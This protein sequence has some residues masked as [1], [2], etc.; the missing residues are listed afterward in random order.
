MIPGGR[1]YAFNAD[2]GAFIWNATGSTCSCGAGVVG[3]CCQAFAGGLVDHVP[4][5]VTLSDNSGTFIFAANEDGKLYKVNAANG[6]IVSSIDLKRP[7]CATDHLKAAPTIQMAQF[8]SANFNRIY[9]GHDIIFIPTAYDTGGACA[10]TTNNRIFAVDANTMTIA[11][12]TGAASLASFNNP[13]LQAL[14]EA[15]EGCELDD[16]NDIIYCAFR[17]PGGSQKSLVALQTHNS[18]GSPENKFKTVWAA[19]YTTGVNAGDIQV[20][21]FLRG[22]K[23]YVANNLGNLAAYNAANGTQ[24]WSLN[25]NCTTCNIQNNTWLESRNGYTSTALTVTADGRLHSVTDTTCAGLPCGVESWCRGCFDTGGFNTE[26]AVDPYLSK[27]YTGKTD[28]RLHQLNLTTGSDDGFIGV[29]PATSGIAMGDPSLDTF[30]GTTI[31][32]LTMGSA[33]GI[34][35]RICPPFP[36]GTMTATPPPPP[37]PLPTPTPND[38][39]LQTLPPVPTC[40]GQL[41][42]C[43]CDADCACYAESVFTAGQISTACMAACDQSSTCVSNRYGASPQCNT[44]RC[45][46]A[47][48]TCYATKAND[49]LGCQNGNACETNQRCIDGICRGIPNPTCSITNQC[50]VGPS[51][52]TFGIGKECNVSGVEGECCFNAFGQQACTPTSSSTSNCGSCIGNSCVAP[53]PDCVNG[54]CCNACGTGRCIDL[55]SDHG[56][57]GAC[58]AACLAVDTCVSGVCEPRYVTSQNTVATFPD[59]CAMGGQPITFNTAGTV[60]NNNGHFTTD[61]QEPFKF[62][63][64]SVTSITIGANGI[65]YFGA[66]PP[67]DAGNACPRLDAVHG[68]I[69][70][71]W[72]NLD[73]SCTPATA[74]IFT[75]RVNLRTVITWKNA[76][77]SPCALAAPN[78]IVNATVF[79]DSNNLVELFYGTLTDPVGQAGRSH[80]TAAVVGLED[81]QA[82]LSTTFECHAASGPIQT[83]LHITLTPQ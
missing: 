45:D 69:A 57:C 35:A 15:D 76:Q 61:L 20:R 41:G 73:L 59:A 63:N 81:L 19:P 68:F 50:Q 65:F 10:T 31:D 12:N 1:L 78:G 5:P 30:S 51:S 18:G 62:Y 79:L 39:G 67:S 26:P 24:T 38:D 4:A 46:I 83:N 34:V 28:G 22:T 27:I 48:H 49:G 44:F 7:G 71:F 17:Q 42:N 13:Y 14:D 77:F 53:V 74:C 33:A 55:S 56:N 64:R 9:G 43:G 3:Q 75:D 52:T 2:S 29:D 16:T 54:T 80:G 8:S 21:P 32:R 23:I 70:P 66:V 6:Q 47:T 58:N 40:T 36:V 60:D 25:L 11:W 72:D 82:V 37:P